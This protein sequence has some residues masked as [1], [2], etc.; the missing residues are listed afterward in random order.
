MPKLVNALCTLILWTT[1]VAEEERVV[2]RDFGLVLL[3][4]LPVQPAISG[5]PEMF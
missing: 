2:F 5:V 1:S 4:G 3:E